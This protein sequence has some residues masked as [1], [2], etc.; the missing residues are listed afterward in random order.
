MVRGPVPSVLPDQRGPVVKE[1]LAFQNLN[2]NQSFC[3]F[4]MFV[5]RHLALLL[6]KQLGHICSEERVQQI[7]K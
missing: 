7:N 4:I 5:A 3:S 6:M 2:I 1:K